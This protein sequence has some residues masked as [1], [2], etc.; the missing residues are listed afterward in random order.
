MLRWPPWLTGYQYRSQMGRIL[1][2]SERICHK[3]LMPIKKFLYKTLT[4]CHCEPFAFCHSERS[5]ESRLLAQGKLRFAISS[6]RLLCRSHRP[7]R[8]DFMNFNRC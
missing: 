6:L 3:V 5:E 7:P 8:N 2:E 1:G 4:S